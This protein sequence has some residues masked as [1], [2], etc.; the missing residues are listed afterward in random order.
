MRLNVG[1]RRR[2]APLVENSRRRIELL[3][4]LLFSLPGTPII[5]YGD[6]IGMGDNIYLGDRNGVRTPMQWSSDRNGGFSRADPA[7]LYAPPIMDP[8][9]GYQAI[10]V[11]AQERYP[12]SLLHWMKRLIA[13]R[14]QHRVFGR[15]S[16]EFV[17]CAEPQGA[18]LPAP[19]RA[20]N[21]SSSSPTCRA[22]CS[23]PSSICTPFAGLMPVEM[24]GLTEFPRDRRAAVFPDARPVRLLL[25]HAAA[26]TDAGDADAADARRR[27]RS[28]AGREPAGA[29]GRRRLGRACSTAARAVLERQA[30]RA[31]P[32]APAL[33]RVK[34]REIREVA[35]LATGRR[36][37]A[38]P[39]PAFLAIVTVDLRR[40]P[41]GDATVC[42]WRC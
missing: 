30:L 39:T 32:A 6:E 28:G 13:L 24:L 10:N 7:R 12:F 16:L 26:R 36:S 14:K 25:V 4:S 31:V 1:I 22:P 41:A 33:V 2:L 9:Y 19:R 20:R 38:A 17:G 42:R 3:N 5:Y 23:R 40:R 18:R 21:R 27:S 11:E 35:L 37:A 8:V 29:A 34:S 15:G